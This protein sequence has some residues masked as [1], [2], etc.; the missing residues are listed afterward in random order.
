MTNKQI[1]RT[2]LMGLAE[3]HKMKRKCVECDRVFNLDKEND[4]DEWYYGH[5]CEV[6]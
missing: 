6:S 1:Y 2:G 4:A 3:A 5:D